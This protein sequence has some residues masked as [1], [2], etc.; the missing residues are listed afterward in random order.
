MIAGIEKNNMRC[1]AYLAGTKLI[2]DRMFKGVNI[3]E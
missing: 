1:F 2:F 3:H